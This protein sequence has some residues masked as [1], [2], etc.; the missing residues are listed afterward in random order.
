MKKLNLK[1]VVLVLVFLLKISSLSAQFT[2]QYSQ[3][4]GVNSSKYLQIYNEY[5]AVNIENWEQDKVSIVVTITTDC[6]TQEKADKVFEKIE[7]DFAEKDTLISAITNIESGIGSVKYSIDYKIMMPAYLRIGLENS[8][9]DVYIQSLTGKSLIEVKYGSLKAE[10]LIFGESKPR[11]VVLLSYSK[12]TI[13]ECDWLKMS[14]NFSDLKITK[15]NSLIIKSK[16]SNIEIEKAVSVVA[17]SKYDEPFEINTLDNFVCTGEYS[18]FDIKQISNK[19]ECDLKYSGLEVDNVLKDFSTI[20]LTLK[21]GNVEIGIAE[22]SSYTLDAN[23]Q[24]GNI[25]YSENKNITKT[26][27]YTTTNI[28]GFVG[29]SRNESSKI[30]IDSQYANV[31]IE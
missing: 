2:K 22:N 20:K 6:K 28:S 19:L 21:Y 10:K 29:A 30:T 13:D 8:Y 15:A 12:A 25:E 11:T 18:N 9:G 23:A 26:S 5:G 7:I 24:Y 3:E 1:I 14:V 17:D 27:D 16:Y 4:Y 31:E